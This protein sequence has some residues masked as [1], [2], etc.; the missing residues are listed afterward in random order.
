VFAIAAT[1]TAKVFMAMQLLIFGWRV[2]AGEFG[3]AVLNTL[4]Q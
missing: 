4:I 2:W 3:E 1:N